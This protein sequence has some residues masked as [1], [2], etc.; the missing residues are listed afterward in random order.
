MRNTEIDLD[1]YSIEEFAHRHN[2][3][4]SQVYV[5]LTSGRLI[6]RKVGNRTVII[7]EDAVV[8]RRSLPQ[9][10]ISEGAGQGAHRH[11]VAEESAPSA[12]PKRRRVQQAARG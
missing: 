10:P 3:S 11:E 8:W 4:R 2:I 12:S 1:G 9:F 5:E 7:R 6:G